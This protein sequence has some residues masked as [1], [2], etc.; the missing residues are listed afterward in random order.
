MLRRLAERLP[1][2]RARPPAAY[3][4]AVVL[5][6]ATV[7]LHALVDGRLTG[8]SFTLAYP[9]VILASFV[10]GF[11]PGIVTA[12]IGA[13]GA[14]Y[15]LLPPLH[16][17]SVAAPQD[18]LALCAYMITTALV[19]FG[20]DSLRRAADANRGL[21][22]SR[23]VLLLELQHRV[24]N[25]IQLV[26]ALLSVQA[27]ESTNPDLKAGLAHARRRIA[28]VGSAYSN[29]YA[30]GATV[31]FAAH[32]RQVTQELESAF[33]RPGLNVEVRADEAHMSMDL[34]VP[35]TLIAGEMITNTFK[36][37]KIGPDA[38]PVLVE[39]R[40]LDEDF[41]RLSVID[42]GELPEDFSLKSHAGLGLKIAQQL[43]QQIGGTIAFERRPVVFCITFPRNGR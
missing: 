18:W 13:L 25:H 22:E 27:R 40:A 14:G 29:L 1:D 19:A 9:G 8:H 17:L 15:F 37:A 4:T 38:P 35:L 39:F 12:A 28:A 43:A 10:A 16:S 34:V 6:G 32:L 11:W 2:L 41:Y 30:P 3:A 33:A 23:E 21:A 26:S 7:L 36:H 42:H 24:K 5:G 20:F 31:E